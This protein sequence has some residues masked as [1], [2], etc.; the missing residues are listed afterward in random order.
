[1]LK[2]SLLE[3]LQK[4]DVDKVVQTRQLDLRCLAQGNLADSEKQH[5]NGRLVCRSQMCISC[6]RNGSFVTA[7]RAEGFADGRRN[8]SL[9]YRYRSRA[10]TV[11]MQSFCLATKPRLSIIRLLVYN[12]CHGNLLANPIQC[13]N[14][15]DLERRLDTTI[16]HYV[17]ATLKRK[18]FFLWHYPKETTT[19]PGG[20]SWRS[21]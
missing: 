13:T 11:S 9:Q 7:K 14:P 21:G 10:D 8:L 15:M 20:F 17:F 12:S 19:P 1:M 2:F 3:A 16:C 18:K 6:S 4:T 5:C